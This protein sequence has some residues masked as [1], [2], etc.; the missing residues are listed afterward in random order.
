MNKGD[1]YERV[2]RHSLRDERAVSGR[3]REWGLD[4]VAL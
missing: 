4:E 3:G 2:F 1:L